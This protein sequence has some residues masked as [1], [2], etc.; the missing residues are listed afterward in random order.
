MPTSLGLGESWSV[1]RTSSWRNGL[2]MCSP[3]TVTQLIA[4]GSAGGLGLVAVAAGGADMANERAEER[5]CWR[6]GRL[7][8]ERVCREGVGPVSYR[9]GSFYVASLLC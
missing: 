6:R 8:D 2:A 9:T 5:R 7:K 4:V 3:R 1:T